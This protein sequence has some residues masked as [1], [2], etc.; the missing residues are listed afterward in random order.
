MDDFDREALGLL[1]QLTGNPDAAFRDGQLEAIHTVVRDRGRALVVQ[2]TGWG[3]SAVYLIATSMLRS[4]GSGPTIIVSPLLAL[5]RNQL[6]MADALAINART[7]NSSNR[8][9]WGPIFD[10]I[11][12][13][14][15]D[16][17]LISP[18]RLNNPKFRADVMPAL[19]G[20]IGLLVIDEVHCISD[21]GHDF[22]PDYR[23]IGRIVDRL[24]GSEVPVLGCTATANDRVM[25]RTPAL[26]EALGTTTIDGV[27]ISLWVGIFDGE[28]TVKSGF[29]GFYTYFGTDGFVYV[30]PEPT[31][32]TMPK[33]FPA[34][35]CIETDCNAGCSSWPG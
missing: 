35:T 11:D 10:A 29:D 25:A 27:F 18:E 3:K 5:M 9:D 23:R 31:G 20:T 13:G 22:R 21:W 33:V 19:L 26:A 17:L 34:G 7:V 24:A 4:R 14:D 32:P 30:F 2:R 1:R 6:T 8:D 12:A 28:F 15:V 16:L